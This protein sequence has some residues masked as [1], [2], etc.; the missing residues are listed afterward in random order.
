MA[1]DATNLSV[2]AVLDV[3]VRVCRPLLTGLRT[4]RGHSSHQ[5]ERSDDSS[6]A[7]RRAR[8]SM[9][10]AGSFPSK[11]LSTVVSKSSCVSVQVTADSGD[12]GDR[13]DGSGDGAVTASG[14]PCVGVGLA[15]KPNTCNQTLVVRFYY[16]HIKM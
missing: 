7:K 14:G 16:T 9:C 4:V 8:T 6:T 5:H 15:V 13:G 2:R 1:V 3:R 12:S 10:R 11:A